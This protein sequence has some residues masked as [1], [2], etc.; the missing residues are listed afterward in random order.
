MKKWKN[1]LPLVL[2]GALA[3][4]AGAAAVPMTAHAEGLA[5][6]ETSAFAD[7]K[8]PAWY[9]NSF[10][11]VGS[12]AEEPAWLKFQSSLPLGDLYE[13]DNI[14][15]D[16]TAACFYVVQPGTQVSVA[17]DYDMMTFS[18]LTIGMDSTGAVMSW[19]WNDTLPYAIVNPYGLDEYNGEAEGWTMSGFLG[20]GSWSYDYTTAPVMMPVQ[21]TQSGDE[22]LY[23]NVVYAI[24]EYPW[25]YGSYPCYFVVQ[26]ATGY[27]PWDFLQLA[28]GM[29]MTVTDLTTGELVMAPGST[30]LLN[31]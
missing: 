9:M 2:A 17:S 24:N 5:P 16:E 30:A 13:V 8:D 1:V 21:V 3:V 11:V 20:E 25:G 12:T 27:V 29:Q 22:T 14:Y 7:W 4:G 26:D 19:E 18:V 31:Q 23:T 6:F 10:P 15:Y 28:V